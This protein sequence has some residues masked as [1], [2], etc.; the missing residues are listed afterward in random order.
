MKIKISNITLKLMMLFPIFTLLA[1]IPAMTTIISVLSTIGMIITLFQTGV[2]K[3]GFFVLVSVILLTL[4]NIVNTSEQ[5]INPNEAI[6]FFYLCIF[7]VFLIS[8]GPA[9]REYLV[10]D[11]QYILNICRI[12]CALVVV[13]MVFRSSYVDGAFVSFSTNTFRLSPSAIFIMA[14]SSILISKKQLFRYFIYTVIPLLTILLGASRTYLLVGAIMLII[15]LS[16][17]IKYKSV[18]WFSVIV[19]S[20]LGVIIVLNSSMGDKFI[21][22]TTENEYLDPLA[23]F[24]SGRS[25]FWKTDLIA[26]NKQPVFNKLF[27]CGFNFIRITNG[28][29]LGTAETGIWAHNDFIQI[30]ITFGFV[31][32]ALY[33]IIIR[34]LFK[35]LNKNKVPYTIGFLLLLSWFF[36][37]TFNMYYVYTCAMIALPLTILA[38]DM[39]KDENKYWF[40]KEQ[41]I[42]SEKKSVTHYRG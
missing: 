35:Y 5:I 19:L 21:S 32:L 36:N 15:N 38:C 3:S 30:V 27:G 28:A 39:Y 20:I 12:W 7:T 9:I 1:F 22:A 11:R 6:Y 34:M 14:L 25:N 26:F 16:M 29:I 41:D 17:L 42:Q 18:F 33:L 31:G 10:N 2:K 24:T 8:N 37:A 4:L 13:S 40:K 23:V